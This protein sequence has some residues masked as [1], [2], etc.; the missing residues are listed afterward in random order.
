[1]AELDDEIEDAGA[2]IVWVLEA[3]S[4][5]T[6]GTADLCVGVMEVLGA[7]DRGWCVGDG[8]TAPVPG[9]FDDS[10]FSVA[11]GFDMIVPRDTMEILWTSSH[12]SPSGNDN[13]DGQGILDAVRDITGR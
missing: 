11:R 6:A 8:Q 5:G 3:D 10:P 9:T 4:S 13:I 7:P 1:V 2:G 12:G